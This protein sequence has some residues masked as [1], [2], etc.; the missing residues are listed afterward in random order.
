MDAPRETLRPV[1][2]EIQYDDELDR[3]CR[4][5]AWIGYA[6][7]E[8]SPICLSSLLA[9]SRYGTDAVSE[10]LRQH[11]WDKDL[12]AFS[13]RRAVET[14]DYGVLPVARRLYSHGVIQLFRR[15]VGYLGRSTGQPERLGV[16]HVVAT[17]VFDAGEDEISEGGWPVAQLLRHQAE[18][19]WL[20]RFLWPA[21]AWPRP[22]G[23]KPLLPEMAPPRSGDRTEDASAPS[24]SAPEIAPPAAIP[25]DWPAAAEAAPSRPSP[26]S[27]LPERLAEAIAE[28]ACLTQV[29]DREPESIAEPDRPAHPVDCSVFAPPRMAPGQTIMVQVFLHPP[30]LGA[31]AEAAAKTFDAEARPRGFTS[32]S[33]DLQDGARAGF[34]LRVAGLLVADNGI[35]ELRWRNRIQG[36]QFLVTAPP[37]CALGSHHATLIVSVDGMP[38]GR[39]HF[40]TEV[41]A[42]EESAVEPQALGHDAK[43]YRRAFISYASVDRA[44][45][46]KRVQMLAALKIKYFQD[47]L[48]LEPGDRW[49]MA[50]YREIDGCDL[51]L[52]FWSSA[53][54][55]SDWVVKEVLYAL[56]CQCKNPDG[57]PDIIPVIIEGPPPP[58][59]PDALKHLHFNDK[60]LYFMTP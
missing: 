48:N 32:L 1:A 39:V 25:D 22:G 35:G 7:G 53:A 50:L 13:D 27:D 21:E 12:P 37:E 55:R 60:L 11:L 38:V 31:K 52:L 33:L 45:V 36:T 10:W 2:E 26:V 34:E 8:E 15:A 4:I 20:L 14:A 28:R 54:G 46:L 42:A 47:L 57:D 29:P 3:L 23:A 5:A 49:Q 40:V 41:V 19:R 30:D 9:A 44:E 58:A 24:R 17:L 6:D 59:P 18:F 16:R 56:D 51:F 43:R